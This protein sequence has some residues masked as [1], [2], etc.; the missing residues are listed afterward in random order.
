MLVNRKISGFTFVEVL[1]AMLLNAFLL[2]ALIAIFTSNLEHYRKVLAYNQLNEQLHAALKL[3]SDDIRRAGYWANAQNDVGT[4]Q[5]NNPFMAAGLDVAVTGGNCILFS[6]DRNSNGSLPS[7]ATGSDDE[8]YGFRLN[9][10]AIQARP[11]GA[12]FSCAAAA[13][14]WENLT[15]PAIINITNLTFTLNQTTLTTGPGTTGLLIRSVD[16]SITG[17]LVRDSSLTE[18]LTQHVRIRNDKFLP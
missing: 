14:A 5:N 17:Q 15:D 11:P 9:G 13:T 3:M 12:S 1:I 7:I 8:R 16:I 18:T 4:G 6:Y 2:A 10:Q